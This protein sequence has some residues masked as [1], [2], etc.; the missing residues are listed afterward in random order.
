[1]V[2]D[3]ELRFDGI[4]EGSDFLIIFIFSKRNGMDRNDPDFS[5]KKEYLRLYGKYSSMV[6]QMIVIVMIGTFGGKELDKLFRMEHPVFTIILILV[7][8]FLSLFYFF[9]TILKK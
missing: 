7:S 9:R 5:R 3:V 6:F 2:K 1:L 8:A 4:N